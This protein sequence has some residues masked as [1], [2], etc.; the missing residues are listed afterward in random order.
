MASRGRP[1]SCADVCARVEAFVLWHAKGH[2]PPFRTCLPSLRHEALSRQKRKKKIKP[3]LSVCSSSPFCLTHTHTPID[4]SSS[5][6]LASSSARGYVSCLIAESGSQDAV[7]AAKSDNAQE[8]LMSP[9]LSTSFTH[10]K[11]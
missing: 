11:T 4:T 9:Y 8:V 10:S 2:F 1:S 7:D 6:R 5:L 3:I